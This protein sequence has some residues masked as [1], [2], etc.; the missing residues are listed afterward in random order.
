LLSHF[1]DAFPVDGFQEAWVRHFWVIAETRL[2]LKPGVLELLDTLDQFRLHS[3]PSVWPSSNEG[4]TKGQGKRV[5]FVSA[6][7]ILNPPGTGISS[8][9]TSGIQ[10]IRVV[11]EYA[12]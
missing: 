7:L 3:I 9:L 11:H 8:G 2:A 12:R 1:G 5:I 4:P 10:R 6:I